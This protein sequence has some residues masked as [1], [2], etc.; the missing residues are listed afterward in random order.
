MSIS[1]SIP[2]ALEARLARLARHL[3]KP[4][5]R[6][7]QEAVEEYI[8]RHQPEAVTEA[9]NRVAGSVDTRTDQRLASAA[10]RVLEQAEW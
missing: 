6:V 1:A 4:R 3:R 7:L 2:K 8:A 9:M 5:R 10:R